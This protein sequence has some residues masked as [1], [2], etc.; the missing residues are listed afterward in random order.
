MAAAPALSA[1]P[2]PPVLPT[3]FRTAW[4][5]CR[6]SAVGFLGVHALRGFTPAA[7]VALTARLL[8]LVL[9]LPH[10]GAA[11]FVSVLPAALGLIGVTLL[12]STLGHT[13]IPLQQRLS[14]DL[15]YALD[16]RTLEVAARSPLALFDR[17]DWHDLVQAAG[18]SAGTAAEKVLG[19]VA[20][21]L[22][23][24]IS[25][26]TVGVLL[27]AAARWLPLALL[28][29]TLVGVVAGGPPTALHPPSGS[30]AAPACLSGQPPGR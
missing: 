14:L 30:G 12:R 21:L 28:A 17:D 27:A 9:R 26:V 22:T 4:A 5:A 10:T 25:V 15:H 6:W 16:G 13:G 23:S 11:G 18:T 19:Q 7:Q 3:L 29:G 24:A 8:D 2:A 20:W 1:L